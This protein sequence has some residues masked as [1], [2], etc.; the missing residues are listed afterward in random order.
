MAM[1]ADNESSIEMSH[2][3]TEP[4]GKKKIFLQSVG[5]TR[6]SLGQPFPNTTTS[7]INPSG[8]LPSP[9]NKLGVKDVKVQNFGSLCGQNRVLD[10]D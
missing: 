7:H 1:I 2:V 8:D 3:R 5:A 6:V 10:Q 9:G 4:S